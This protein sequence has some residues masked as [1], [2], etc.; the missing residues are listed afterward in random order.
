MSIGGGSGDGPLFGS[1][2]FFGSVN[3]PNGSFGPWAGC[4]C[5]SLFIIVAGMLLVCAGVMRMFNF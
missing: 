1:G 4:G 5:S 2:G 3:R